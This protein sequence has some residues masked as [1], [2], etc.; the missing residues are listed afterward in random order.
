MG[1]P[2]L[3]TFQEADMA[4]FD[5]GP[6]TTENTTVFR[7]WAPLQEQVTLRIVDRGDLVM[8]RR[9]EGWHIVQV[10][11]AGP[12]TQYGFVLADGLVVPDPGS[13]HQ[14]DDVHGPSELADLHYQWK[15]TQWYGRPWEETV[16]YELHVGT[17]TQEG[18]F[19]SAID[20][21][22]HLRDLG[23][24]A[25]QIMPISDFPGRLNWGYDGVLP[26]APDSAYGRPEDLQQ[27]IDEAHLRG[28][29]VF[30]DVVYNHFG[31]DGN[32]MPSYAPLF[33][34][35]HR[36][37]WGN[38]LNFDGEQSKWVRE[39]IV[40]NAEYWIREFK[41]DGLRLDAVHAID[42]DSARHILHEIAD[43]ARAA[44]PERHI[45]LIVEN[46][47]N[48]ATLL[49][50]NDDGRPFLYTAQWNDDIHHVL[51]VDGTG[52]T[53]GYYKDYAKDDPAKL[54]KALAEGFVFQG[55]H[56]NYRGKERG[57]PSA[58]LPPTAF[59][60]FIQNH[61]QI[62]N[63]AEG[64]RVVAAQSRERLKALA[65]VYL[66]APQIPMIFMGEEWGARAP[67]PYFCD[68][69]PV[70]NE[71]VRQGRREEL[72]RLP[73]FDG[74]DALDP[75]DEATF[76]NAKLNW[77]ETSGVNEYLELYRDLLS[78]RRKSIVPLLAHGAGRQASYQTV[79][80]AIAVSWR[81][82]DNILHLL[83]NLSSTPVTN[84]V[85]EQG[86]ALFNQGEV[87]REQIG[88][89]SVRWSIEEHKAPGG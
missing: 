32:Y 85:G 84:S 37:P 41:M 23:V 38:G 63:R 80:H 71:K 81:F 33:T 20:R 14:P 86:V 70:L 50:R 83:A 66:L 34:N 62:G 21:L 73:C 24:T 45:H 29:C 2:Y 16:I 13:R 9:Y 60:S 78:I 68:F 18:T 11:D 8:N 58:D 57:T 3:E 48:D 49:E 77:E 4:R 52:E 12:G 27:L 17:F 31:P 42:D 67:F 44:A 89:W 69:A 28:I 40:Q 56:M 26:Y 82:R 51:H 72:S 22:D 43:R 55:Q 46:E 7:L 10:S 1:A 53:F 75:T 36:T 88:A 39:F 15:C 30:L 79:G 19:L 65:A 54:G 87:D 76:R 59:I 47:D 64:D 35:K 74:D 5:F 6:V 61:D 25:I